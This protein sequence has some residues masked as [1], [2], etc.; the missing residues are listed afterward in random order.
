VKQPAA[1]RPEGNLSQIG[2]VWISPTSP[3]AA[4][5]AC[6]GAVAGGSKG[7][8][9]FVSVHGIHVASQD[10]EFACILNASFMNAPDGMPLAWVLKWR[11]LRGVRRVAGPDFMLRLMRDGV[12]SGVRHYLYGG[13]PGV[14]DRLRQELEKK[15]PGI[16][17]VGTGSPP[18]RPLEDEE[19]KALADLIRESGAQMIWIGISTPKQ[20]RLSVHLLQHL[21]QGL[22]LA[23]GAA[24]DYHAGLKK[25]SPDWI[26]RSGFQWLHRLLQD[27]RRLW[28]RYSRIVPF[29]FP[30]MLHEAFKGLFRLAIRR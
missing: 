24:F 23:V 4:S 21:K 22:V 2:S 27:P 9:C 30:T 1:A 18:Y 11:G 29:F 8:V 28:S 13:A 6:L 10:P 14:A 3:D 25:D 7:M 17:I 19:M 20:E 16:Q 26:K 5:R 15:V 12:A